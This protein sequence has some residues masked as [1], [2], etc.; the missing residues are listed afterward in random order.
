MPSDR[1]IIYTKQV[2]KQSFLKLLE[3]NHLEQLTVKALCLE[4]DI[5]RATFYR[6]YQ[7]IYDLCSQ[8]EKD[9]IDQVPAEV[10]K[11]IINID[12]LQVFYDNQV[13]YR[14]FFRSK[15][16]SNIIKNSNQYFVEEE[17]EKSKVGFD[18]KKFKYSFDYFLYGV[19]GLLKDWVMSG[20]VETPEEF[21]HILKEITQ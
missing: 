2:I 1:R 16:L 3:T 13:F 8:I 10:V 14:E 4:A 15:L 18:A 19:E 20:C 21:S 9:L 7:D 12:V 17:L 6:H 5:N 11:D